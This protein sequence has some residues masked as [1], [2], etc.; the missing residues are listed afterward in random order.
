M[1]DTFHIPERFGLLRLTTENREAKLVAPKMG[2]LSVSVEVSSATFLNLL[3]AAR[4]HRGNEF[5]DYSN[6]FFF[7]TTER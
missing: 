7:W 1:S 2:Q 5:Q 4:N 6:I 3:R